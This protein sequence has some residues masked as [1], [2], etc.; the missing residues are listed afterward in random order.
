MPLDRRQTLAL[1]LGT[2]IAPRTAAQTPGQQ[3]TPADVHRRAEI[4][5]RT[6]YA[7]PTYRPPV[8]LDSFGYDQYR[9]I[10]FRRER[11]LWHDPDRVGLTLEFF[12]AS[13]IY[14][15]PVAMFA[16]E[17]GVARPVEVARDLFD[18]GRSA[19]HVPQSGDFAFSGFRVHG[20]LNRPGVDDEILAFNGA[21][22][23]RALGKDHSYGLSARGLAINSGGEGAEE[24][25]RFTTFWVERPS[26]VSLLKIHA[27]LDSPSLAGA[28]HF[29]VRPGAPTVTDVEAVLYPRRR[30]D[31]VGLA[32]LTSMF[33]FDSR[34]RRAFDD[35][36]AAVH[37]SDGLAVQGADGR[38]IWRP[39]LNPSSV[40]STL[41]HGGTPKGFGLMQRKRTYKD[42]LDL[43]AHY[44]R[45]P[46]G[47][48]MPQ[49]EW[50][51]GAVEL[52]ELSI[53]AEWGDNIV[54]QWR[55][56]DAL[57]P[58]RTLRFAYSLAWTDGLDASIRRVVDTR[59]GTE[60]GR[61]LLVVDYAPFEGSEEPAGAVITAT[62]GSASEAIVQRNPHT[63]GTRAFFSF[64]PPS[65]GRADLSLD[66]VGADGD[67]NGRVAR[68]SERWIY[69]LM[70]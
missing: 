34:T 7:A 10:R 26:G 70:A 35:Y 22:Y 68:E 42:F 30:V 16:V 4:L 33:L 64:A 11:A 18:F 57:E 62:A 54:T 61:K 24:F 17:G 60:N 50:P 53:G 27:L 32:P 69:R 47:W 43:E 44:E 23:F 52:I 56:S 13:Y 15:N 37:D 38:H 5:A 48:V 8:P 36:R 63:G 20:P 39:L 9:D 58:G 2:T 29:T 6:P 3:F 28:Y 40:E 14:S 45:R 55:L 1:L 25:P 67:Q 66:L 12:L 31:R 41:V 21:S 49:G 19:R 46:G 65:D 59:V 51:A